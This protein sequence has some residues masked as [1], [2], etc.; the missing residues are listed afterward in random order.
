MGGQLRSVAGW[1]YSSLKI[2]MSSFLG[3]APNRVRGASFSTKRG[4]AAIMSPSGSK[5]IPKRGACP[6]D[7]GHTLLQKGE[8]DGEAVATRILIRRKISAFWTELR[9][10]ESDREH[11]N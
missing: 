11:E 8:F 3:Q 7:K 10:F 2:S 1:Q 9:E 4:R 5:T 6:E